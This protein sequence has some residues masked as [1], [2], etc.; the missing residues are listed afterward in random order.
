MTAMNEKSLPIFAAGRADPNDL[1]AALA[2]HGCFVLESLFDQGAL[3]R[4]RERADFVGR[5]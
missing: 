2:L 3:A 5:A 1:R 4:I